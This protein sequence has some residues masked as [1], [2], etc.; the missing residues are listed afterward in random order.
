MTSPALLP[1]A[2]E[3]EM[4]RVLSLGAGV[5]STTLALMAAVGDL[6]PAPHVAIFADTGDEPADVYR[7]LA[8]LTEAGRLPFKVEIVRAWEGYGKPGIKAGLGDEILKAAR[9][10]GKAGSHSRP[11][12]F[13]LGADGSKGMIRRQC[14]GDFKIDPI[15]RAIRLHLG[16]RRG[17]RWPKE[18]VVEQWVGISTDEATRMKPSPRAAISMRW[19]LIERRMSRRD[20]LTW[21]HERGYPEPPKSACTFCPFH[22]DAEWRRIRDTDPAGWARAVEIDEAIRRGLTSKSLTGAL[23]LHAKREPLATVDLTDATKRQ[24]NLFENDCTGMCGV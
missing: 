15:E 19:P 9:G 5:Q 21:L 13:T 18:P 20:C 17:Q 7:H 11:P 16:L 4:L 8:W 12:F 2:R 1:S 22:S 23:F 14:T 3:N 6:S 10:E 24:I